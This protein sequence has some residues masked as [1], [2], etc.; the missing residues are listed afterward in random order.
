MPCESYVPLRKMSA[1]QLSAPSA[2]RAS[3]CGNNTEPSSDTAKPA[4]PVARSSST[5][6]R[7]PPP[8][9][10]PPPPPS[11]SNT[12]PQLKSGGTSRCKEAA[13][14]EQPG[15]RENSPKR[16]P[17]KPGNRLTDRRL[18]TEERKK[19]A[20]VAAQKLFS[21]KTQGKACGA[22]SPARHKTALTRSV[23][24]KAARPPAPPRRASSTGREASRDFLTL[25]CYN[26][27]ATGQLGLLKALQKTGRAPM[28]DK[29][30]NTPLH[31]A[32][33][34]GQLRCLR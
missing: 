32:A 26:A 14:G 16:S 9:P 25:A 31:V 24:L 33:K 19:L 3:Q 18:S 20:K 11:R 13:R 4:H 28:V 2:R 1:P 17:P 12:T 10:T 15:Q 21:S 5:K 7:A 23:S 30:G 22:H 8:P 6:A 34:C 27:V 29:Q